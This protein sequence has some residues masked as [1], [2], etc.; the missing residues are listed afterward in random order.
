MKLNFKRPVKKE[1]KKGKPGRK[2]FLGDCRRFHVFLP[3]Q[4]EKNIAAYVKEAAEFGLKEDL[5][6]AFFL[7]EGA[8]QL[9]HQRIDNLARAKKGE[10]H[11]KKRK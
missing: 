5:S 2:P 6:L 7:R 3:N 8:R 10:Y 9:L 11:A 1:V 4:L